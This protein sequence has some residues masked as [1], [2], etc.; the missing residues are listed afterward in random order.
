MA[1]RIFMEK[2]ITGENSKDIFCQ[3]YQNDERFT[4]GFC[5]EN[6]FEFTE[7]GTMLNLRLKTEIVEVF[8]L[9]LI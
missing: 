9:S 5:L 3:I 2:N 1:V 6:K 4:F 7:E 8:L